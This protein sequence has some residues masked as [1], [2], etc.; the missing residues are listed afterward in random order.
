MK[1]AAAEGVCV[2]TQ[3]A[4]FT[5]AQFG[6]CPLGEDGAQPTKFI[7]VP[8]RCRLHVAQFFLG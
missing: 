1:M 5:V 6:E 8:R 3:G 7:E 2:D 4:A